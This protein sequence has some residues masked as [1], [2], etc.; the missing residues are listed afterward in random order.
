[1]DK[2]WTN[3]RVDRLEKLHG[4]GLSMSQIER[5]FR[6]DTV[7]I[8]RSA[9]IGKLHRLGLVDNLRSQR[10]ARG[11]APEGQC[12]EQKA[13]VV[14]PAPRK[15]VRV[16]LLTLTERMCRWPLGD[17]QERDFHFCGLQAKAGS[18]YC[19]EHL[20]KAYPPAAVRKK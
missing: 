7:R 15:G 20:R 2:V 13:T 3:D 11:V 16:T 4:Q 14:V 5:A 1:M 10:P 12:V 19:D 18:P 17:P 6:D 8:S 9:I